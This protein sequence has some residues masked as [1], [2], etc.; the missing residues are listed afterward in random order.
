MSPVK[1]RSNV[2]RVTHDEDKKC[3]GCG[4]KTHIFYT[5]ESMKN[6]DAD[7]CG[8]CFMEMIIDSAFQV[9]YKSEVRS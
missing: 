9:V 7:L 8:G 1:D 4:W 3:G 2:W 5:F 6:E